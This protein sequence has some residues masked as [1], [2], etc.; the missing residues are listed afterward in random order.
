MMQRII[1]KGVNGDALKLYK[2]SNP[3]HGGVMKNNSK[4]S[5]SSVYYKWQKC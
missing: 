5:G 3:C 4:T 2:F 1:Y